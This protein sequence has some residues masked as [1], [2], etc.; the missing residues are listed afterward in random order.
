MRI[1]DW[2]SDVC[3]SDLLGVRPEMPEPQIAC[4]G[5]KVAAS[6]EDW[7]ALVPDAAPNADYLRQELRLLHASFAQAPL[8]GSLLDPARSLKNDLA[9]SSFDT[10]R[11]LLGK[12][13]SE[14]G[15]ASC[16]ESVC[17]YV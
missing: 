6:P 15:R 9:T 11:S 13:L 12:A 5:L 7:M 8:L 2:S 1:S 10:L 4:C 14:I 17:Q 3:S 16:R